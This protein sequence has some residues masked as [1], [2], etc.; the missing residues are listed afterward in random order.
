MASLRT[1]I[2]TF[3]F[4]CIEGSAATNEP[5][6]GGVPAGFLQWKFLTVLPGSLPFPLAT[7]I[8]PEREKGG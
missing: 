6:G 5:V 2:L 4:A 3:L 8:G 1:G 7:P